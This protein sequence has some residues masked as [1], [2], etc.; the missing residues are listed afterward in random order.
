MK[1]VR[2]K[3]K[4]GARL[5][6]FALAVQF[7]LSFGH[8]HADEVLAAPAARPASA[9]AN[10]ARAAHKADP[11]KPAVQATASR[12]KP[13]QP[14]DSHRHDICA[15]CA[16]MALAGTAMFSGP[17]ILRLPQAYHLLSIT[18]DAEFSHLANDRAD[19]QPRAPPAS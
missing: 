1:W 19:F 7:V 5:A 14:A 18:T 16:V 12:S 9:I 10:A 6:L 17:P 15:I 3:L 2:S 11:Q 13:D 8:F 4:H